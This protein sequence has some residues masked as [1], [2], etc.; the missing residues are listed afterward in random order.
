MSAA[1][2]LLAALFLALPRATA[3]VFGALCVWLA[4]GA[5]REAFR[6]RADR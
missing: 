5:A 6:R 3:Y 4:L 2:V 1:L